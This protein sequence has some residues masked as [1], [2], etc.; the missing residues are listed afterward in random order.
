MRP[1]PTHRAT[2]APAS[3]SAAQTARGAEGEGRGVLQVARALG[4]ID[5]PVSTSRKNVK[6]SADQVVTG[7]C[8][9]VLKM[10]SQVRAPPSMATA[11]MRGR[12]AER[13][14][15]Q[16]IVASVNTRRRP[17]L[18]QTLVNFARRSVGADF[19]FTSIQVNKNYLSALHVDKN[20]HGDSYI[21]GV[22]DYAD[23]ELWVQNEGAV[24]C[25]HR[26]QRFNG[27]FPH[28]TLPYAGTRYTL[29]FFTQQ[30]YKLL[31]RG[32]G[33]YDD[34]HRALLEGLGFPLPPADLPP[35]HLYEPAVVRVGFGRI[36]ISETEAPTPLVSLV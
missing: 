17:N 16:G 13:G 18:T 10:M 1:N 12:L 8:L 31:G 35:K 30:S 23:G 22:G 5:V 24:N 26:W 4:S 9:G 29:I 15:L 2:L 11:A 27:N 20:N 25:R 34:G 28:C 21:I 6:S 14:P 32:L 19:K 7:M 3:S 36:V 33:V